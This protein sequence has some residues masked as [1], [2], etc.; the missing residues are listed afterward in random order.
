[1]KTGPVFLFFGKMFFVFRC[2]NEQEMLFEIIS[3]G[4]FS[5]GTF[6]PPTTAPPQVPSGFRP[7]DG[8]ESI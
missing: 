4:D 6:V 3:R 1:M 8:M 7:E 5:Q 2:E